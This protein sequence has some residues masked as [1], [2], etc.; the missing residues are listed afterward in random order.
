[1][2]RLLWTIYYF[3]KCRSGPPTV[4][5]I[6]LEVHNCTLWVESSHILLM[7]DVTLKVSTWVGI[8]NVM[9]FKVSSDII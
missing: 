4:Q 9:L 6:T 2:I 7:L 5:N 8:H 1:M 3:W